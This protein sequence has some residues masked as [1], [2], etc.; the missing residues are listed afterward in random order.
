[1]IGGLVESP[2]WSTQFSPHYQRRHEDPSLLPILWT[3]SARLGVDQR[4]MPQLWLY[5]SPKEVVSTSCV[6]YE[7]RGG[8]I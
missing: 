2:T 1:M 3:P 4:Q 8:I 6:Y 5:S 7:V